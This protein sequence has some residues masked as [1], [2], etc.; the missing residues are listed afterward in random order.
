[1]SA[2]VAGKFQDHYALLGVDPKC[3]SAVIQ[4]AYAK[5]AQKYNP[6]NPDTGDQAKFDAV[7]LAFE[8]LSDATTRREFDKIKGVDQDDGIPRFSGAAFF[9][10]LGRETRLRVALLCILYDRRRT[11]P[12]TPSLS[13][14]QVENSLYTTEEELSF[15]LW[16]LKQRGLAGQD[17]K[18]SLLITVEG[19]DF[20]ENNRPAP[21][22]VLPF[23]KPAALLTP[24][25]GA[26]DASRPEL[27]KPEVS[28][29]DAAKPDANKNDAPSPLA[30]LANALA[31]SAGSTPAATAPVQAPSHKE[32][33]SVQNF[34]RRT[35]VRA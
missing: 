13:M 35:R 17:D 22:A 9:E 14:R 23:I 3:D 4:A 33:E 25:P 27:A 8:V 34:M 30:S 20:L 19:M 6:G 15:A 28:N 29:L 21:E 5:W 12:F 31:E 7:N 2:P 16:Y 32:A 24:K 18:S 11:K 10:A 1:M 26:P